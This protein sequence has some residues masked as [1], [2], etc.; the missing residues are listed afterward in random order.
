MRKGTAVVHEV[1]GL[2][3]TQHLLVS[4][5]RSGYRWLIT[6]ITEAVPEDQIASISESGSTYPERQFGNEYGFACA[7]RGAC[8]ARKTGVP[9]TEVVSPTT[10]VEKDRF[11]AVFLL[12]QESSPC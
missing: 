9:T 6:N 2:G 3:R 5:E 7:R 11:Q 4:M 1:F 12:S 8:C 10:N